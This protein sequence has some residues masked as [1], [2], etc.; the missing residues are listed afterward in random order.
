MVLLTSL[1][2]LA[3]IAQALLLQGFPMQIDDA[4]HRSSWPRPVLDNIPV[5]ISGLP[6]FL[7][8]D[9]KLVVVFGWID[10]WQI[11]ANFSHFYNGK[12]SLIQYFSRYQF[13]SSYENY[14]QHDELV[15]Y[16]TV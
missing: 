14:T 13:Y 1:V 12:Q 9:A 3:H 15:K 10:R 4:N 8:F 5:K 11:L 16:F 7:W 6:N 2:S